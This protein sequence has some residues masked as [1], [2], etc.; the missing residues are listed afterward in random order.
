MRVVLADM[1]T[2][3]FADASFD[4]VIAMHVFHLV[5]GWQQ[6]VHEVLR[7]LRP[8]GIFLH[9]WDEREPSLLESVIGA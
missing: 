5:D 1:T 7:V 8:G 3:P 6:A 9:F 4:V 2:V